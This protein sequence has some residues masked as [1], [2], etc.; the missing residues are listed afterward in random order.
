[1]E[2]GRRCVGLSLEKFGDAPLMGVERGEV[3]GWGH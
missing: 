2:G 1:M 3:K